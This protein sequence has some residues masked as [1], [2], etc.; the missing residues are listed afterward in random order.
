MDCEPFPILSSILFSRMSVRVC[1]RHLEN[2]FYFY[3]FC[4]KITKLFG[5]CWQVGKAINN[6]IRNFNRIR[7]GHFHRSLII[8]S[9]KPLLTLLEVR[10]T[11]NSVKRAIFPTG[12]T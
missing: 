10:E 2:F 4:H 1:A 11:L 3:G 7:V 9:S 8:K 12:L 6:V 5:T